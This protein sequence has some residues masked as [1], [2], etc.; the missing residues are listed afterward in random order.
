MMAKEKVVLAFSGGVDTS[1]CVPHLQEKGYDVITLTVD[2]GGIA[3]DELK[4]IEARSRELG[5]VKHIFA[6]MKNEIYSDI[7][8]YTIKCNGLY[9]GIYPCMCADRFVIAKALADAAKREGAAAVAHG[10]TGAG[11]DQVRIDVTLACLNPQ[12]KI[13]A[14]IRELGIKREEEIAYLEKK[15]FAVSKASKKYTINENVFGRTVSG[16][17]IDEGKEPGEE[18]WV[19]SKITKKEPE[20]VEIEFDSGVPVSLNGKKIEGIKL[21]EEANKIAGSH[22]CGRVTYI[23]DE[24]IGIKGIQSFEAPGLLLLIR[25]HKALEKLTLTKKQLEIKRELDLKW[26]DYNFSGLLY[27][28]AVKDIQAF[29]D[30]ANQAVSGKVKVKLETKCATVVE[31]NSSNT[32]IRKD[33]AS[34]AQKASWSGKDAEGFVKIYG[35][36]QRIAGA[37]KK[38]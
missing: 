37:R 28:P 35:M 5:A 13:I 3:Q 10:C 4:K 7:I 34:Y 27:E 26:A 1:F 22:G 32:L 36:G 25:A 23:E 20:Y 38:R 9:E 12:L 21:L 30:S 15:G 6:D 19:L 17:E 18:A 24:V 16:S 33:I 29:A 14:P 2:S 8:S 31:V 11:N